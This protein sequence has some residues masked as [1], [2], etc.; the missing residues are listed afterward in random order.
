MTSACSSWF[1]RKGCER[2]LAAGDRAPAVN[3]I[4]EQFFGNLPGE[5]DFLFATLAFEAVIGGDMGH[6]V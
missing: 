3:G 4:G 1:R 2:E 5:F 6:F